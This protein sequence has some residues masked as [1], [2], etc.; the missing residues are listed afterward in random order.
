[1]TFVTFGTFVG[2]RVVKW[3]VFFNSVAMAFVGGGVGS[4]GS[5]FGDDDGWWS[6]ATHAPAV[7]ACCIRATIGACNWMFLKELSHWKLTV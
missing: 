2:K 1:V 5:A 6:P 3:V 7:Q 4:L